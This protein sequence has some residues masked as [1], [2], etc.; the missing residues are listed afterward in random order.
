MRELQHTQEDT[1][2][3]VAEQIKAQESCWQKQ[4]KELELQYSELLSEVQKRAQVC[5]SCRAL[6]NG[7][8]KY[9]TI[10]GV[11]FQYQC[12]I[13]LELLR[14]PRTYSAHIHVIMQTHTHTHKCMWVCVYMCVCMCIKDCFIVKLGSRFLVKAPQNA[15]IK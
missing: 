12:Q 11:F 5:F 1:F 13:R 8:I 15:L 14:M 7:L 2:N 10:S 3:K 6:K 4:K 9:F